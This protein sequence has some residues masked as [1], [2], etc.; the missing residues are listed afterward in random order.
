MKVT[1]YYIQK[2]FRNLNNLIKCIR[3]I[4]RDLNRS[5]CLTLFTKNIIGLANEELI[6]VV[7]LKDQNRKF[8]III[9]TY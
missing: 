3:D 9:F 5:I 8:N 1:V 4:I 6:F 2:Y 7:V